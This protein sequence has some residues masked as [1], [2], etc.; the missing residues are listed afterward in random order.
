MAEVESQVGYTLKP[1]TEECA[2]EIVEWRY[3]EPFAVYNPI[4]GHAGEYIAHLMEPHHNYHAVFQEDRLVGYCCFGEDAQVPG[5]DYS[6]PETMDVGLGMH[7][8]LIGQG[9]GRAFLAAILD[10]AEKQYGSRQF[11]STIATFNERSQRLFAS[12][13]FRPVQRFIS[14][15]IG[16]MEFMVMVRSPQD[17]HS[18]K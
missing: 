16:A 15:Q 3:P 2:I 13:G 17:T 1:M 18:A 14:K 7:P 6:L 5:G 12:A 9:R 11:R 10:F 8:D 4:D